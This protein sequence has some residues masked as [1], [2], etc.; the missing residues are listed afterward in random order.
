MKISNSNQSSQPEINLI[1]LLDVVLAILCFFVILTAGLA[2]SQKIGVDLPVKNPDA[3]PKN[4]KPLTQMLVVTLDIDGNTRIDD[5][6]LTPD[7]LEVAVK[8]YISAFPEGLVVL[9]AND[10]SVSY[11]QVINALE[12]LRKIAGNRVAIATSKSS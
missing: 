8:A 1:P 10:T 2:P 7:G 6:L 9:N 11:Q 4:T 3:A 12:K 5:K